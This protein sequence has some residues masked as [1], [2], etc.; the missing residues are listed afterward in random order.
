MSISNFEPSLTNLSEFV[1]FFFPALIQPCWD[2]YKQILTMIIGNNVGLLLNTYTQL[3]ALDYE[4]F[5]SF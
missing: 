5:L 1:L 2:T 4:K 3:Q